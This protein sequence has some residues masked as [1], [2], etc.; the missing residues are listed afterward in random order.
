MKVASDIKDLASATEIE[1]HK[2]RQTV[3]LEEYGK[4][5]C[6]STQI[7][8]CELYVELINNG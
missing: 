6:K 2:I 3:D 4:K 1:V 5:L 7:D 8:Y